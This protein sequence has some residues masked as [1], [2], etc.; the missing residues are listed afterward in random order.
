MDS[1]SRATTAALMEQ[2]RWA[3]QAFEDMIATRVAL[4]EIRGLRKQ[5]G[6]VKGHAAGHEAVASSVGNADKRAEDIQTGGANGR[7]SGLDAISR[8]FTIAL[9]AIE[10]ADRTPPSQAIELYQQSD[11]TLKIRLSEWKTLKEVTVP[12]LNRQ[13]RDSGLPP[14]AIVRIEEEPHADLSQ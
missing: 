4:S 2:F 5:I 13:L 3:Q 14:L 12:A 11:R 7:D 9:N 1:R 10:G 6:I 8:T